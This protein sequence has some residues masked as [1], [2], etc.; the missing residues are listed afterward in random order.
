MSS[1]IR[2]RQKQAYLAKYPWIL[3]RL[4][5]DTLP[6]I[7]GYFFRTVSCWLYGNFAYICRVLARVSYWQ[8]FRGVQVGRLAVAGV[9]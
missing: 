6:S 9:E 7:Q 1:E 5:L 8:T 4:S 2:K 3:A